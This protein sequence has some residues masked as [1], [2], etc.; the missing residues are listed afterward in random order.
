[1]DDRHAGQLLG[2][3]R[4]FQTVEWAGTDWQDIRI[5]D[6]DGDGGD[7]IV[8]RAGGAWWV[9]RFENG[10]FVTTRWDRGATSTGKT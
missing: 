3:V 1:M 6:F 7:D 4:C 8:A 2:T 5:G 10:S 9:M